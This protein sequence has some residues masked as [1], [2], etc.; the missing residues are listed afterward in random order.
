MKPI[1]VA[2]V[3]YLECRQT[4]P[5]HV[6]GQL[7]HRGHSE[8][9]EAAVPLRPHRRLAVRQVQGVDDGSALPAVVAG[10]SR[11]DAR[12]TTMGGVAQPHSGDVNRI[13]V[14]RQ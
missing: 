11:P 4:V 13:D 8:L 14:E 7:M 10:R 12:I 6:A 2:E 5:P 9:R 1:A 3:G